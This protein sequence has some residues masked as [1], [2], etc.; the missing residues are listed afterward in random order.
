ML[1]ALS[2]NFSFEISTGVAAATLSPA[3]TWQ[4]SKAAAFN[5]GALIIR[6]GF[7]VPLYQN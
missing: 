7:G 3:A 2:F 1:I 4:A 6:I 5:T